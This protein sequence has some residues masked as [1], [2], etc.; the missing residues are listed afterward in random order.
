MMGAKTSGIC[1]GHGL[2]LMYGGLHT[3]ECNDLGKT[4][5][6]GNH[7]PFQRQGRLHAVR[8]HAA[9]RPIRTSH[10]CLVSAPH[11][12]IMSLRL[13]CN[14]T[15]QDCAS[16]WPR[17]SPFPAFSDRSCVQDV[18]LGESIGRCGWPGA[19]CVVN[20][21]YSNC[22]SGDYGSGVRSDLCLTISLLPKLPPGSVAAV[23]AWGGSTFLQWARRRLIISLLAL[24]EILAPRVSSAIVI[25]FS[26]LSLRG[27]IMP[28]QLHL[29]T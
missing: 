21:T 29:A 13:Q 27:L 28:F 14:L 1:S 20:D 3:K 6:D 16:L 25:P 4:F 23:S 26:A 11:L 18:R 22:G 8:N 15:L 5:R 17:L 7:L 10:S 12:P 2:A 24:T 9:P 19:P